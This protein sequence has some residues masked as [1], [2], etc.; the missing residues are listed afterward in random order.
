MQLDILTLLVMTAVNLLMVSAA[1]PVIM[2]PR[3]SVAARCAQLSLL[4]QSIAW[5][6]VIAA[7]HGYEL[8]MMTLAVGFTCISQWLMLRALGGWLG[9]RP[10]ERWLR[11]LVVL[12]PLGYLIGGSF[13]GVFRSGWGNACVALAMLIVARGTLMPLRQSTRPWRWLLF[14]CMLVMAGL[15]VARGVMGTFFSESYLSF[16]TPQAVNLAMAAGA[17][18]SLVL[19]TVAILVAWREEAEGK[20]RTMAMTDGLTGLFNR[21]GWTDRAEAMFA[22]AQRYQ[23]PLTMIM[24]DLD[25]FK[26]INDTHG[27]EVGDQA[28]KL[29]ARLLRE[30]RRTG[31]LVGRLGG[32]EFCIV[33]SNTHKSASTGFDQRLRGR[34]REVAHKELGFTMDFSAGVAVLK[35]G[36]ATLAGLLARADLALY[37]AKNSGRGRMVM[38]EGGLGA[39]VI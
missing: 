30:T 14:G 1:L 11:A 21:R 16:Q 27:H 9:H 28:L 20:L 38:S 35:D 17:N 23:Q 12:A 13:N 10:G 4:A 29:F 7:G 24:L 2:G 34:L 19:V 33:L 26:R 36:D 39:T 6:A 15:V 37:Q 31:D 25:H 18:L 5:W 32:E 3:I 22:N 8:V